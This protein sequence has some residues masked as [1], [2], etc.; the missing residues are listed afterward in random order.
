MTG[1]SICHFAFSGGDLTKKGENC[2]GCLSLELLSF[3]GLCIIWHLRKSFRALDFVSYAIKKFI[4][5]SHFIGIRMTVRYHVYWRVLCVSESWLRVCSCMVI[6]LWISSYYVQRSP[7]GLSLIR[8]LRIS[9]SS[10]RYVWYYFIHICGGSTWIMPQ[11]LNPNT[12]LGIVQ[13][14]PHKRAFWAFATGSAHWLCTACLK[15]IP[16]VWFSISLSPLLLRW[17]IFCLAYLC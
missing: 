13:F 6:Q 7:L 2:R 9:P 14:L 8:W 12:I 15:Y 3:H 10:S 5:D 11:F 16:Y 4:T 17:F 1:F